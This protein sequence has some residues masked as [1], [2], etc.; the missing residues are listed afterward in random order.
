MQSSS[1]GKVA[2]G[3]VDKIYVDRDLVIVYLAYDASNAD[4]VRPDPEPSGGEFR[5]PRGDG[6]NSNA[7][8][9]L[10][11]ASASNRW[12]VTIVTVNTIEADKLAEVKYL[13]MRGSYTNSVT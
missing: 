11:L 1:K 3:A 5:I 9:S 13:W 7:L 10:A 2:T 6:D 12:T 4:H 8:F